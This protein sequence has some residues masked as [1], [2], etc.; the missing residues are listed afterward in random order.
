MNIP[1]QGNLMC[2]SCGQKSGLRPSESAI[3]HYATCVR[4]RYKNAVTEQVKPPSA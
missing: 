2:R 1:E 3:W 4:C